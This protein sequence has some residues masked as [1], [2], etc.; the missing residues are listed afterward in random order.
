MPWPS[1]GEAF[2]AA[3]ACRNTTGYGPRL[4]ACPAPAPPQP[5]EEKAPGESK[6]KQSFRM[7]NAGKGLLELLLQGLQ[8]ANT[9][10]VSGDSAAPGALVFG[11][12][13]GFFD[14]VMWKA[15]GSGFSPKLRPARQAAC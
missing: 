10:K 7:T 4:A 12:G 9:S 1:P 3:R 14:G 8:Q 5:I 2:G 13:G 11:G 6:T 15:R